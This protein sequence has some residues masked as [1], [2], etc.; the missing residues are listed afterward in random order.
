MSV[1]EKERNKKYEITVAIGYNGNKRVNHYETFYGGKK[2]AI[3]REN[4]IK[5][6]IKN[7]T[8]KT[9]FVLAYL[10]IYIIELIILYFLFPSLYLIN[11]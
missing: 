3:L 7:N 4:E 6:Q 8:F 2:E 1:K 10:I 9:Y 11:Q 5:M